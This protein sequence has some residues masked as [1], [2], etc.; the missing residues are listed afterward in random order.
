MQEWLILAATAAV[1]VAGYLAKRWLENVRIN[2]LLSR[3]LKVLEIYRGL[4]RAG[5]EAADL[6]KIE[7][8]LASARPQPPGEAQDS[9]SR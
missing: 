9:R 8:E 7:Q 5:L 4:R 2:E 3:R 6:Q 1:G